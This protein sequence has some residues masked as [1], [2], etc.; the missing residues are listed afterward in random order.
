VT[1]MRGR[2]R[3]SGLFFSSLFFFLLIEAFAYKGSAEIAVNTFT[4][5]NQ[6]NPA[7]AKAGQNGNFVVV[8]QSPDQDGSKGGIIGRLFD[9]AGLPL[10]AEFVVNS[11]TPDYQRNPAVA[12]KDDG[13]FVVVWESYCLTLGRDGSNAFF[14]EIC[15]RRFD[16]KGDPLGAE[17]RVNVYVV[18]YQRNPEIGIDAKGNFVVVWQSWDQDGAEEGVYARRFNAQGKPLGGEIQVNQTTQGYQDYPTVAVDRSGNFLVAWNGPK[19]IYVRRY[20]KTGKASGPELRINQ[21]AKGFTWYPA[22]AADCSGNFIVAWQSDGQDGSSWGITARRLNSKGQPA[23]PEFRVNKTA[24]SL[25]THPWVATDAAGNFIFVWQSLE[26]DGDRYGIFYR[27][28][29]KAG[30]PLGPDVRVNLYT[31][32]DQEFPKVAADGAGN[33][34]AAWQDDTQ[35]GSGRGVFARVFKK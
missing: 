30:K 35:D 2:L 16:K 23:G 24:S 20:A 21:Y 27:A 31:A 17:F 34:V 11:Y 13:S 18:G 29:N 26:Q 10:S 15:A 25:Q 22:A 6:E 19:G 1:V 9:A 32:D 14:T 5:G 3:T 33:F 7:I 8:W 12:M 4:Q 28:F